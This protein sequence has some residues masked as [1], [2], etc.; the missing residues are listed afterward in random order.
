LIRY[1]LR[2][3]ERP[4]RNIDSY[5]GIDSSRLEQM[6]ERLKEDVLAEAKMFKGQVRNPPDQ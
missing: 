5:T 4:M 1:V 6:E 2:N 3:A